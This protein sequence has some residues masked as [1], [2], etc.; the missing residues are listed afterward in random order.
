VLKNRLTGN[1]TGP[2]LARKMERDH[3]FYAL[4]GM[5]FLVHNCQSA[6]SPTVFA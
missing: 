5:T 1:R 2:H 6:L 4:M 3:V